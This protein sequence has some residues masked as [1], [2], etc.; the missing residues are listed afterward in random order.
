MMV[1]KSFIFFSSKNL[2]RTLNRTKVWDTFKIWQVDRV[3]MALDILSSHK[4]LSLNYCSSIK[5]EIHIPYE[6]FLGLLVRCV[7]SDT[8]TACLR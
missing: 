4:M 8:Q 2:L 6:A 3:E 1:I 7:H 5:T